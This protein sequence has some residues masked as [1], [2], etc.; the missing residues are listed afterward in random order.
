MAFSAQEGKLFFKDWLIN[1]A[2]PLGFRRFLDVGCGA[3]IYGD[4]IREVFGRAVTINAVEPFLAYIPRHKLTEKYDA[5][6][7]RDIRQCCD[8]VESYDLIIAGDVLEHLK[9]E[10][11]IRV[12]NDLLTKCRFFWGALPV[13]MGRPWSTGYN[14]GPEDYQENA[15][16]EHLHD[17]RGDEVMECFNPLFLV[18]YIQTGC[19]LIEGGIR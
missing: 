1:F 7:C 14:Q 8:E 10:E 2:K 6:S 9:R 11:A 12:V 17:W 4:L 19:F 18:P 15:L 13:S 16:N 3:G 5:I